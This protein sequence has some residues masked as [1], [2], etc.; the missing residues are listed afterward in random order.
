MLAVAG[1]I[2]SFFA[3][4]RMRGPVVQK[5]VWDGTKIVFL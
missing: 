5:T 2:A 1:F 4:R 3:V